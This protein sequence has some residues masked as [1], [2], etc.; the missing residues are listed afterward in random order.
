MSLGA[1]DVSSE[2]N[3]TAAL[4]L[5]FGSLRKIAAICKHKKRIFSPQ[6]VLLQDQF[7]NAVDYRDNARKAEIFNE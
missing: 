4:A 5:Y 1:E 2:K 7:A 6:D 3:L